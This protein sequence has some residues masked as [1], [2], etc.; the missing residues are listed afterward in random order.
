ME[1]LLPVFS[2]PLVRIPGASEPLLFGIVNI[3]IIDAAAHLGSDHE[4]SVVRAERAPSVARFSVKMA[5]NGKQ[6]TIRAPHTSAVSI[7][8]APCGWKCTARSERRVFSAITG[9]QRPP[10]PGAASRGGV[11][12][13]YCH[14]YSCGEGGR[15]SL[16]GSLRKSPKGLPIFICERLEAG[17]A[18]DSAETVA[19]CT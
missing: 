13:P 11:P 5:C 18:P 15:K 12:L 2:K 7:S 17:Q 1:V 3:L 6:R 16:K 14:T 9:S 19:V 8:G 4:Q 10:S